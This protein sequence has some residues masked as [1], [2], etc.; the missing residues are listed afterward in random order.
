M[1]SSVNRSSWRWTGQQRLPAGMIISLWRNV[2]NRA[3]GGTLIS[4]GPGLMH[5]KQ[6]EW[7]FAVD[8]K[9]IYPY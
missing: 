3:L 7:D 2:E 5:K 9:E 6:Y 1:A 4:L 8:D